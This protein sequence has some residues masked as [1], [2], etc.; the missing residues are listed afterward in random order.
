MNKHISLAIKC[1]TVDG[2]LALSPLDAKVVLVRDLESL[3]G[4]LNGL[5]GSLQLVVS[6]APA[7]I[8]VVHMLLAAVEQLSD[9]C[10]SSGSLGQ[11]G[12]IDILIVV[13]V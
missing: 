12:I 8:D 3:L 1:L 9:I 5:V 10:D 4:G 7:D 6:L 11:H 13:D 2:G